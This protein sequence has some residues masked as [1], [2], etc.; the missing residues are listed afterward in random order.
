MDVEQENAGVD[1]ARADRALGNM[2]EGDRNEF[3]E[4]LAIIALLASVVGV[5]SLCLLH[6]R[7]AGSASNQL[8]RV[9]EGA[10]KAGWVQGADGAWSLPQGIGTNGA[11]WVKP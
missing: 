11:R 5:G 9:Q 10:R 4:S 2:R 7:Q 8:R 1:R 6:Q 3:L